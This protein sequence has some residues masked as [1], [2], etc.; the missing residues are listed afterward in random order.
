MKIIDFGNIY[1]KWMALASPSESESITCHLEFR[2]RRGIF[3]KKPK[4]IKTEKN[5]KIFVFLESMNWGFIFFIFFCV[6]ENLLRFWASLKETFLLDNFPVS[7]FFQGFSPFR[8]SFIF[9]E[10]VYKSLRIWFKNGFFLIFPAWK[11]L[12]WKSWRLL[13]A[14][15]PLKF[16]GSKEYK[17]LLSLGF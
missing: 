15:F 3:N 4:W 9:Q 13:K 5:E 1:K 11:N 7:F 6:T 12:V 17:L 14:S 2:N 8:Q 10:F 16:S